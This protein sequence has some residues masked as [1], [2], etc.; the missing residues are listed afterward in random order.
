MAIIYRATCTKNNKKYYGKTTNSLENRKRQHLNAAI[1][2][3]Q[4]HFYHAIRKHGY[5]CFLWE[6]IEECDEL[7]LDEREKYWIAFDKTLSRKFGYNMTEGG[8]GGKPSAEVR[9]K[10]SKTLTGRPSA[11]KGIPCSNETKQRISKSKTGKK[12]KPEFSATVSKNSKIM[13]SLLS[14]EER[15]TRIQHIKDCQNKPEAKAKHAKAVKDA[16]QRPEVKEKHK[17]A[18]EIVRSNPEFRHKMCVINKQVQ[19][20][21]DI[22]KRKSEFQKEFRNRHEVKSRMS[23]LMS[24][25]RWL[26]NPITFQNRRVDSSDVESYLLTGWILGKK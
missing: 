23:K 20:R 2:N 14:I 3:V 11:R 16:L 26:H 13:W 19:N 5:D 4:S 1:N 24:N 25:K 22:R 6:I 15:I 21:P 17:L 8:T 7:V 18:M 9:K 10:I 12:M